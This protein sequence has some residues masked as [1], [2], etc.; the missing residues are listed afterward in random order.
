MEVELYNSMICRLCAAE[1]S[2]ATLLYSPDDS[3]ECLSSL[4]NKYLPL[5][6]CDDGKLPRTICPPCNLQLHS[7]RAFL[8]HVV[9]GQQKIRD[10]WKQQVEHQKRL[11]KERLRITQGQEIIIPETI[12]TDDGTEAQILIH[13]GTLFTAEHSLSLKME[14][15]EK[16]K[17][18]RGRPPKLR[19]DPEQTVSPTEATTS[20]DKETEQTLN[21]SMEQDDG[22][23]DGED[24]GEGRRRRRKK[25]PRR[26]MEAVQGKELERMFREEGVIDEDDDDAGKHNN[27]ISIPT[28][29]SKDE[30]IGHLET[31]DGENLGELVIVNRGRGRGR[32]RN[33]KKRKINFECEICGRGFQHRS[34]YL[35]HKNFHKTMKYECATCQKQFNSKENLELHHKALEHAGEVIIEVPSEET[36]V[37]EGPNENKLVCEKCDKEFSTKDDYELHLQSVHGGEKPFKCHV[38]PMTFPYQSSL[39]YHITSQHDGNS[40]QASTT[41]TNDAKPDGKG[42]YECDICGKVLNHP[43]SVLYHK[44]AEHNDGRRFVCS[45][46]GKGFKHKQLLQ[47]H[48]LVHSDDRPYV[49]NDCGSSFKTK[50]NW[51]NHQST[52][53]GEKKFFCDL[54]G[55]QFAHKT[56]LTLHYRWHAGHKP[57]ECHVCHKKFSQN[58]NLQ[59]HLR[60]HSGEKPFCCD[61]CGRKFTTSSQFKLHVKRHTGERPWKCEFCGKSFLHKDTWK[62]HTRRH[63]GEKPFRCNFCARGFTEQWALKKH[64]RL[65]TGEKPYSCNVCGKAFADCSNLTKHKKVHRENKVPLGNNVPMDRA[66][67]NIIRTQMTDDLSGTAPGD[68]MVGVGIVPTA[69]GALTTVNE[70]GEAVQQI[71]YV[72]YQDPNDPTESHTLHIVD[73]VAAGASDDL[74]LLSTGD[75]TTHLGGDPLVG[76]AASTLDLGQLIAPQGLPVTDEE[77]NPIHF[78]MQDGSQLQ[79]TTPDGQSLMVTTEDGRAIPV[80][81]TTPDGHPISTGF[82]TADVSSHSQL[83]VTS[84]LSGKALACVGDGLIVE[85]GGVGG[86]D[87]DTD[88]EQHIEFTTEDGR[89]L[90][91]VASSDVNQLQLVDLMSAH[92]SQVQ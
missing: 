41:S 51:L 19:P 39:R 53:T 86:V 29:S 11:E 83:Q 67:W 88:V 4:V 71:I 34:R 26:F 81:L 46:C 72:S 43:S 14:G 18:K 56:S 48:Q 1:N 90:R 45:K 44:E 87:T 42:G 78:T 40:E 27:D 32:P 15:L 84:D 30:V 57:Y 70:D 76:D 66:V 63:K 8:D 31:P 82:S 20:T 23:E 25:I 73:D 61:Y 89:K 85:H 55:H 52:H 68:D 16:P 59:E 54:C 9:L 38:C 3:G 2:N 33:S 69:P 92:M 47:R 24:E 62:C 7:T 77:G 37:D 28:P 58:G 13:Y 12:T 35:L 60:I 80:Q 74:K 64:M 50:A 10:L 49:C 36:K 75:D 5:Q 65:H 21:E 91:F 6:I 79:I 17:R 22:E